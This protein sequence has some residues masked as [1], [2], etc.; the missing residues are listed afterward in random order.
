M[1][2][3]APLERLIEQL[4]QLPGIGPRSA[5][6]I[7]FH[8]LKASTQA[9]TDLAQAIVDL[10]RTVRP[11]REC[12]GL[13]DGELCAICADTQ[14]DH[15]LICVVEEPKD[16][17]A[18]E[19]TDSFQGVYHVLWG[20]IAPLEGISAEQLKVPELLKRLTPSVRE[21]IVATDH[22]QEGEATAFHMAELLKPRGIKV[23][24][25]AAGLPVGGNVEYTDQ[26]TL[27]R[28]L[29]GRRAL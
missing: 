19:R 10:K 21:V 4:T 22:D 1:R 11:C 26:A 5:E 24:R 14:R 23:S 17:F 18:I 29:E 27:A 28:A 12:L 15:Q 20:S 16:V 25:L 7:A 3:L 6:R 2:R 13:S 9:A 8:C